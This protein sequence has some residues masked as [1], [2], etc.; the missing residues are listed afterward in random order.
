MSLGIKGFT[1]TSLIDWPGKIAAVIFFPGCN[2][3]CHYCY[4]PEFI[5]NPETIKDIDE[6]AIFDYLE[7]KK[8]WL[9]GVVFLGGEP[10][11]HKNFYRAL[12]KIKN[13]GLEIALHTN[14][15]TPK[16]LNNIIEE[17]LIEYIAMDIKAPLDEY[18]KV[19]NVKVDKNAISESVEIIQ[20]SNPKID[21]EFRTTVVPGLIDKDDIKK[22]G[23]WLSG[24][25][26]YYIQQFKSGK[27]LDPKFKNKKPYRIP[28]LL[29]LKKVAEPYFKKVEVRGI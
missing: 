3:R 28:E 4:N 1:P 17:G 2:F 12:K 11:A 26:R 16:I 15:T 9:D 25:K 23:E 24:S 27:T 21:Y 14:G 22:I 6:K 29:N 19:V 10:T 5:K 13:L 18:E 7:K 20:G 8:K